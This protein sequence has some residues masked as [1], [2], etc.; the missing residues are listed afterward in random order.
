VNDHRSSI[1]RTLTCGY[2]FVI[3]WAY[4]PFGMNQYETQPADDQ[5]V[6][7]RRGGCIGT[8]RRLTYRSTTTI[9][10]SSASR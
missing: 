2:S 10:A 7:G 8:R 9:G 1:N 3:S 5:A 6:I 4:Y